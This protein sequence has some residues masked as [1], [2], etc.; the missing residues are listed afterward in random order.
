[1]TA[2]VRESVM[3]ILLEGFAP[4]R[5]FRTDAERDRRRW[6]HRVEDWRRRHPRATGSASPTQLRARVAF[7]GGLCWMCRERPGTTIDHVKPLG[8]GGSLWPA[9]CRP[10]CP[11]CNARKGG[12]WPFV[13]WTLTIDDEE[14]ENDA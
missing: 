1:M 13:M 10:A 14:V 3:V 9:N 6:S 2:L 4:G 11:A 8:S 7:Y 5:R 12:R